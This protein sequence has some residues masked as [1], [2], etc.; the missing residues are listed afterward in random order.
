MLKFYQC[1]QV[2]LLYIYLYVH[3]TVFNFYFIIKSSYLL[4]CIFDERD[5]KFLTEGYKECSQHSY[6]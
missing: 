1:L 2:S 4:I 5:A 3:S 6:S